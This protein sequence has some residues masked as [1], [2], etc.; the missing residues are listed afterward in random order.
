M[1][2]VTIQPDDYTNII[3]PAA[4]T[5]PVE[6]FKEARLLGKVLAILEEPAKK[7]PKEDERGGFEMKEEAT[8]EFEDE[9]AEYLLSRMK[10]FLK[11]M[12]GWAAVKVVYV[13]DQLEAEP[14]KK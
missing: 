8:F 2:D 4:A 7:R 10:G 12:Q 5:G 3:Y 14:K 6:D 1:K 9:F 13:V 11:Q